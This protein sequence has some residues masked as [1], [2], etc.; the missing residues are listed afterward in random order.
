[1][2]KLRKEKDIKSVISMQQSI[3]VLLIY[4][5]LPPF[6]LSLSATQIILMEMTSI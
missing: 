3:L 6:S 1:M 2:N 4:A 5:S